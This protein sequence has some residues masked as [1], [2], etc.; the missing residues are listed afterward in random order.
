MFFPAV[1]VSLVLFCTFAA[2]EPLHVPVFHR[3]ARELTVGDHF[4]AA[5]NLA[6]YGVRREVNARGE[7][8]DVTLGGPGTYYT[9]VE[10]G[11]PGQ[12]LNLTV[13]TASSDVIVESTAC[14]STAGCATTGLYDPSKS[15][16]AVN[17]STSTTMIGYGSGNA[18]GYVFTDNLSMGV[19]SVSA[20][21]FLSIT[22]LSTLDLSP[23]SGLLGLAFAGAAEATTVPFWQA[24]INNNEAV[25]PE[26]GFWLARQSAGS[27]GGGG[28]TFGGVNQLYYS[29]DIEFLS[30]TGPAASFWTLNV[31]AV[32]VYGTSVGV[33][34]GTAL[35]AFDTATTVIAG[36]AAD[37]QAIW[38]AVP[39]ASV[40]PNQAGTYQF[41]C[42]TN[43]NITVSFGGK[44]WTI[45]PVDV[46]FGPV[47][48]GSSQCTGSIIEFAGSG[49]QPRWVFGTPFLRN[50]YTVF[51]QNPPAVGFADLS[52]AAGGT[53][54]IAP[55]TSSSPS[56]TSSIPPNTTSGGP[57]TPSCT[58][59]C[60]KKA[61]AGA[62]AGGVIG[63]L[64][65]VILV[66]GCLLWRRRRQNMVRGSDP[67]SV[68]NRLPPA[69]LSF[70]VDEEDKGPEPSAMS[71]SAIS[72]PSLPSSSPPPLRSISTMKREQ[73]AAVH[74]HYGTAPSMAQTEQGSQFGA[75]GRQMNDQSSNRSG[76]S[77]TSSS[78]PG[79]MKG[80]GVR[81][82]SDPEILEEL[83]N[84]REE[85][86]RLVA[87][88]APPSYGHHVGENPR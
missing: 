30:L 21:S 41:P 24:I 78:P 60:K 87:E 27:A 5:V 19:F 57:A 38:A 83:H 10:F 48:S 6:R 49:T 40:N 31:S 86:T 7:T 25:S 47:S 15:S 51:R 14:L 80:G 53:A 37:V 26:M 35:S 36:P 72:S 29:G 65:V 69:P 75:L 77:L 20:A 67:T 70:I 63:G 66:A 43:V 61:N 22:S 13:A 81:T 34:S 28:F 2:A 64:A 18:V 59:S 32:T 8:Q 9:P 52:T 42:S 62:I 71:T 45:D 68:P 1:S 88:R 23:N 12:T 58:S 50:V 39:G 54:S 4:T 46:N 16:S 82:T 55:P 3:S 44:T 11:T 85:V 76:P 73:T 33:N 79:E 56:P 17:K 84:L 74:Q